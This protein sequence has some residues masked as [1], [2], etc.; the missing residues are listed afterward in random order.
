MN[1]EAAVQM[2]DEEL[3][4]S[5]RGLDGDVLGRRRLTRQHRS[6]LGLGQ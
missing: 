5:A 1:K 2:R 3:V 6:Q 4:E